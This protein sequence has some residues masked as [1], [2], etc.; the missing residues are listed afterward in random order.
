MTIGLIFVVA[1]LV[2]GIVEYFKSICDMF[3]K[4]EVKTAVTQ[5]VTVIIGIFL[6]YAFKIDLFSLNNIAVAP[7]V[8]TVLTGIIVSRGSNYVSDLISRISNVMR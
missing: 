1:I 7:G 8:G 6:A 5:I 4:K 3:L 2:E